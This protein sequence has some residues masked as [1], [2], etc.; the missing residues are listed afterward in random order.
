MA[1]TPV[2]VVGAGVAG[3]ACAR[4]LADRGAPVLVL[5]ASDGVGGRVRTDV[6]DGF[7]LD[8]GF[9]VLL[10]SYPEVA[11]VLDLAALRLRRFEPGALVR[12]QGRF[13]RTVDPWRRPFKAVG[14]LFSPIGSLADKRRVGALRGDVLAADPVALLARPEVSTEAR[15]LERGFSPAMVDRFFRPFFGGV[16]LERELATSSRLFEFL[17]RAF[18]IGDATLPADGM[19]AVPAQLAARL[20]SGSVRTGARVEA[21][22]DGR[23]TLST[24]E[25]VAAS[26]VVVAT[27]APEAHALLGLPVPPMRGVTCLHFAAERAPLSEPVLVLNAEPGGL[28]NDLSVL[29]AVAPEYAPAGAALVHATVLGSGP[30]DPEAVRRELSGWFG[31]EVRRWRLLRALAVPQALPSFLPPTDPQRGARVRRGLYVA[32]DHRT[33]PSLQGA[34]ESGRRAAE[35]VLLERS[36]G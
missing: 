31:D 36:G 27:E 14:A 7:R 34:L 21:V 17:F 25:P 1:S 16:F 18:A 6:V 12:F 33:H 8:R 35:A 28:V 19:G 26:A 11:R 23:V 29:S 24:G 20:P 3:L 15:L 2:V 32:G 10:T 22:A 5:E 30:V 9:Q 4:H 13:H